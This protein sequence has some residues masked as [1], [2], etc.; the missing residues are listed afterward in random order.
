MTLV[1]ETRGLCKNFGGVAAARDV[2]LTI[3]QGARHA[4]IGPNGAG[5]TTLINLITGVLRPSTGRILLD[6]ADITDMAQHMRVKRGMA[7]TFQVS[8]LFPG[9]TPL[10]S[11]ALAVAERRG[12]AA[13]WWRPLGHEGVVFDEAAG[14]LD[15]VGLLDCADEPTV[16]LPYGRQRLMEIALALAL[17]PRLLL[18]D[19]P[20]AGVPRAESAELFARIAALPR[21]VTVLLIEHDMDIVFRFA[22]R[23]TVLANGRILADGSP[24]AV[25]ANAAV[26]EVYLGPVPD[27]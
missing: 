21:E 14:L 8:Q 12:L 10:E 9:L 19:E 4:L 27:A 22:E 20:A 1:L 5:K 24:E 26:R 6:G 23:I 25:A 11:V 3:D 13:R 7:R 17:K 18:L 15:D 2:A 16:R